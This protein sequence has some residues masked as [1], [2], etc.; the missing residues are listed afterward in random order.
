[1]QNT[2]AKDSLREYVKRN[3][4]VLTKDDKVTFRCGDETKEG[5]VCIVDAQGTFEQPGIPSYDILVEEENMLY[6]HVTGSL[7]I[8]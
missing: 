7:I 5:V 4:V 2:I 1:M 6:K 3:E 8:A